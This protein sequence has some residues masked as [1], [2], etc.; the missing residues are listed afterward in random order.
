MRLLNHKLLFQNI[1]CYDDGRIFEKE[2]VIKKTEEVLAKAKMKK[3]VSYFTG[4]V[5]AILAIIKFF[6]GL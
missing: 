3:L 5:G 6:M 4:S 1:T 2:L